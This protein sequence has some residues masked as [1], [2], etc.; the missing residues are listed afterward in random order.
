MNSEKLKNSFDMEK[1]ITQLFDEFFL[2]IFFSEKLL[3]E[4][5]IW[6]L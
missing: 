3:R 1:K 5:N 4:I 6:N 2:H